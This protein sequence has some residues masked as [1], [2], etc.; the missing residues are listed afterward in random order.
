MT[1]F[2]VLFSLAVAQTWTQL[3]DGYAQCVQ[4]LP[5][6]DYT[7]S[8]PF[9]RRFLSQLA[10]PLPFL[11]AQL[12][13]VNRTIPIEPPLAVNLDLPPEILVSV[14]DDLISHLEES[15]RLRVVNI[16]QRP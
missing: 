4:T 3:P 1:F 9:V 7:E 5:R 13:S 2:T 11:Q 12:A 6:Q 10:L 15:V 16:P 14:A 8:L